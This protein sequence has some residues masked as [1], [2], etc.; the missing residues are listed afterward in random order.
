[1]V[2]DIIAVRFELTLLFGD[3]AKNYQETIFNIV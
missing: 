2:I 3:M 1:M